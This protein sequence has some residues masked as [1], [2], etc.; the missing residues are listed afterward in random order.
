MIKND[1]SKTLDSAG[2]LDIAPAALGRAQVLFAASVIVIIVGLMIP[3][4]QNKTLLLDGIWILTLCL[5][6]G[7]VMVS[8]AAK[9]LSEVSGFPSFVV[10]TTLVRLAVGVMSVKS[11][12]LIQTAGKIIEKTGD[13]LVA[14]NASVFAM[15]IPAVMIAAVILIFFATSQITKKASLYTSDTVTFKF[16]SVEAD[17]NAGVIDQ[18]QAD[19]IRNSIRTDGRF[20]LSMA[21]VAR[22]IRFDGVLS[23]FIVSAAMLGAV[24]FNAANSQAGGSSMQVGITL[25]LGMTAMVFLPAVIIAVC[26]GVVVNKDNLKSVD[27]IEEDGNEEFDKGVRSKPVDIEILNPDFAEVAQQV[28]SGGKLD[29]IENI[30]IRELADPEDYVIEDESDDDADV[31][32]GIDELI[33]S[34][35]EKG[36]VIALLGCESVSGLPVTAAVNVSA[37]L[38]ESGKKTLLIDADVK[39]NAVYKVFDIQGNESKSPLESCIE[40]L[41]VWSVDENAK[42]AGLDIADK[43][44]KTENDFECII[45]YAPTISESDYYGNLAG[46]VNIAGFATTAAGHQSYILQLSELLTS[47]DCRCMLKKTLA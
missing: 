12:M 32:A 11:I 8:L 35:A 2:V 38:A 17:L 29:I 9:S 39:R 30:D 21:A 13:L 15:V 18:F 19:K 1:N 40:N 20:F 10:L 14:D 3:L 47:A 23:I 44:A 43:I 24:T 6:G 41:F 22:F 33:I 31:S 16:I 7:V 26:C 36:R 46:L 28:S 42:A 25:A 45:I 27:S 5:S 34:R 37:K 4:P